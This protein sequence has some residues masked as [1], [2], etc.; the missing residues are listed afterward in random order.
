[1][2]LELTTTDAVVIIL[3]WTVVFTLSSILAPV[4][5]SDLVVSGVAGGVSLVLS[6]SYFRDSNV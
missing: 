6:F 4:L 5:L 1:M 3:I 2:E